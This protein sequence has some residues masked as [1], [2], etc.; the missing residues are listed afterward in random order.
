M[1]V[2]RDAQPAQT[3]RGDDD[4]VVLAALHFAKPRVD[5]APDLATGRV[6]PQRAEERGSPQTR[7]ADHR[8]LR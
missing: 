8:A 7:R 2:E 1:L 3:R 4:G 6:V 5:V